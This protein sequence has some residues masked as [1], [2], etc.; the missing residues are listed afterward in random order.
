LIVAALVVYSRPLAAG[1]LIGL[2]SGWMPACLGLV[3]LWAGFY[4]RKGLIRFLLASLSVV[5]A[6]AALA[7]AFPPLAVWARALGARSL[8]AAGLLPQGSEPPPGGSFWTGIDVSYRLPVLSA[9]L[10]LVAVTSCWPAEKNLGE[11]IAMSAAL[12]IASQFWYLD[13][14]GTLVLL[15][16]PLLLLMMFRPTLAVRRPIVAFPRHQGARAP[17]SSTRS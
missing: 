9:Y 8:S 15:Y 7:Y 16:L 12:L 1:A 5:L 11:L 13:E 17:L 2:A 4:W 3:P 6:C 10:A 14:G